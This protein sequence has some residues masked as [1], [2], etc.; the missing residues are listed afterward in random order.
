M[1]LDEIIITKAIVER[2]FR[3]FLDHVQ[4]D[5]A[6]VGGGPSDWWQDIFSQRPTECC[7][8]DANSVWEAV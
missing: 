3:K 2:F 4:T 5:V 1:K 8:L 6:I 7:P